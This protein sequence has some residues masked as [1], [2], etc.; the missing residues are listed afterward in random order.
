LAAK[1]C[2]GGRKGK[3]GAVKS[4][5]DEI[6]KG[7][8]LKKEGSWSPDGGHRFSDA[9]KSARSTQAGSGEG[10]ERKY[11]ECSKGGQQKKAKKTD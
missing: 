2:E 7:G 3:W 8:V 5:A 6:T 10:F 11:K 1:I 9:A 4:P